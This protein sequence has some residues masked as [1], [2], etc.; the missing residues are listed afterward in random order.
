MQR[1]QLLPIKN[2]LK[3]WWQRRE[4][5]RWNRRSLV[6]G[7]GVLLFCLVMLVPWRSR[8]DIP[9]VVRPVNYSHLHAPAPAKITQ[10]NVR[11]GES[12]AAGQLL[13]ELESPQIAQQQR[14]VASEL[15]AVDWQLD[16]HHLA[17]DLRWNTQ[18]LQQQR[19]TS[20]AKRRSLSDQAQRL[21]IYAPFSGVVYDVDESLRPGSWV[22]AQRVL[23]YLAD[24]RQFVGEGYVQ[25]RDLRRLSQSAEGVLYTDI[26]R[27]ERQPISIRAIDQTQSPVLPQSYLASV[28]DGPVAVRE[29]EGQLIP[30]GS[31]YRVLL[32]IDSDQLQPRQIYKGEA[33]VQGERESLLYAIYRAVASVLIRE[34]GFC[35]PRIF[36]RQMY[37]RGRPSYLAPG[38]K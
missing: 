15:R 7:F 13:F 2:E 6:T 38:F 1:H 20:E 33:Q 23:G 16:R 29:Q 8:I 4:Q 14:I 35:P 24:V 25:E 9:V 32:D 37:L 12:V 34:S 19:Q 30:E 18:V 21:R 27:G 11:A 36:P 26:K 17:V 22:D 5:L 28:Y 10:I 3:Q 31:I